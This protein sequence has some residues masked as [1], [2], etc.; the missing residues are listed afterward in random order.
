L[1]VDLGARP[2]DVLQPEAHVLA[3]RHVRVERV[4]LEHHGKAA[5]GGGDG[6]HDLAADGDL[7]AGDGLQPRDHPQERGLA[8]ARGADEDAELPL[9]D[10][11][12]TPLMT[13]TAPYDF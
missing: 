9:G 8:A 1:A 4:G 11:R 12:S 7:A 6:V 5:V 13:S 2:V 3:H 10:V